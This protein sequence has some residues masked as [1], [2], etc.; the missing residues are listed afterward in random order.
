MNYG[1]C[2]IKYKII[3]GEKPDFGKFLASKDMTFIFYL[4]ECFRNKKTTF[5]D[6]E[7][8]DFFVE[9]YLCKNKFMDARLLA[10]NFDDFIVVEPY[11]EDYEGNFLADYKHFCIMSIS[12]T[13]RFSVKEKHKPDEIPHSMI[14][15]EVFVHW[16]EKKDDYYILHNTSSTM[17]MEMKAFC[18]SSANNDIREHTKEFIKIQ[19][20]I[21]QKEDYELYLKLKKRFEVA[22]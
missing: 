12:S 13:G 8:Y 15:S 20:E 6:K 21:K 16:F 3:E 14:T 7:I 19:E 11:I 18:F 10:E 9:R 2:K 4:H 17:D 1:K 5:A 22:V